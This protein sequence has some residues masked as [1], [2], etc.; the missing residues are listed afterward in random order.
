M[1]KNLCNRPIP[2]APGVYIF[3]DSTGAVIYIG[4]AKDL[5]KRVSSYFAKKK[6]WDKT[7]A[8]VK[9]IASIDFIVVDS[10]EEAIML[11]SNMIKEHYPKYNVA[12]RDNSPIT[13]ALITKEEFPRL[14]I[15]R[16]D[17]AGRIRGPAG[18]AFGP[19]MQGSGKSLIAGALRK[20]FKVRT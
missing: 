12:L 7:A 1:E 9:K 3:K 8:L 10:E 2:H 18:K 13:Y 6:Q 14:L 15:V 5:K 19:F 16:K 20:A 11:E 4:K 17:R